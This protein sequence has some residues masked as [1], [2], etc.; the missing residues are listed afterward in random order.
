MKKALI[1][2]SVA[3][4]IEQFNMENIKLLQELG[5]EVDVVTNFENGSTISK[6]RISILRQ[7]L[8]SMNVCAVHVPIP[9]SITNIKDILQSYRIVKKMCSDRHYSIVH[10]HSPIGGVIARL[11]ARDSRKNGCKVIYTAHGF[12]FYKGA[13]KKN[14]MMFYPIEKICSLWTD[15][16]VTINREDYQFAQKHMH[17]KKVEYVP[18]VGI[19]TERFKLS[20]FDGEK[21]RQEF[22]LKKEDIVLLSVGELNDNKN[23]ETIIRTLGQMNRDEV[24]YFI[25]GQGDK[26]AYLRELAATL[27]VNLHLLGYRTDVIELYN[28]ADVYICPSK[29]EGLSVALMEAMASGLACVVSKIRGNV[30]LIDEHSG[31]VANADDIESFAEIINQ[32]ITDKGFRLQ[33]GKDNEQKVKM[34]DVA[35]VAP[36]MRDI[37]CLTS[38]TDLS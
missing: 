37:Y 32:M 7:T 11:A 30:D 35:K 4:M 22:S 31:C 26:Q 10:C 19:H 25:A 34:M 5:Y 1:L 8:E 14:W 36:M 20:D 3:S 27:G 2:A 24:H 16:L 29:R 38:E 21:K 23:H 28:M 33:A 18:G 15:V 6:E 12:H 13:P 17:A 9:R